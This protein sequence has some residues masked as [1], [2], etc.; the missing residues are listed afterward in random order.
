MRY[1]IRSRPARSMHDGT[2]KGIAFVDGCC[3]CGPVIRAHDN[4]GGV[5]RCIKEQH[6]LNG[7]IHG[8]SIEGSNHYLCHLSVSFGIQRGLSQKHQVLL[9]DYTQ[10]TEEGVVPDLLYIIL[11]GHKA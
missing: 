5:P 9:R 2:G 1:S 6:G 4:A 3:M 11:V 8:W 7:H 10:L